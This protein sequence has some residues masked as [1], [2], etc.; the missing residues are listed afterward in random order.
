V[1]A[2]LVALGESE[3][4][5]FVSC[6]STE[7]CHLDPIIRMSFQLHVQNIIYVQLDQKIAMN[8]LR[9]LSEVWR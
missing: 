9:S 8:C 4:S 6:A 7:E 5:T 1:T 2:F 3:V